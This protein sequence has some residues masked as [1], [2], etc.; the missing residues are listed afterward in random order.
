MNGNITVRIPMKTNDSFICGGEQISRRGR[1]RLNV[2]RNGEIRWYDVPEELYDATTDMGRFGTK[3][4]GGFTKFF[5]KMANVFRAGTVQLNPGFAVSNLFRDQSDA[6]FFSGKSPF[7]N[8]LKALVHFAK[9]DEVYKAYMKGGAGIGGAETGIRGSGNL[10]D[11]MMYGGGMFNYDKLKDVGRWDDR[12]WPQKGEKPELGIDYQAGPFK[13]DAEGNR[14][15]DD[16]G[17]DMEKNGKWAKEAEVAKLFEGA[18][19]TGRS[20]KDVLGLAAEYSEMVTR[21]GTFEH[22]LTGG[23]TPREAVNISRNASIDFLRMG[24]NMRKLNQIIPFLNPSVKGLYMMQNKIRKA[25][26]DVAMGVLKWGFVPTTGMLAWNSVNPN[27][28]NIPDREKENNYIIMLKGEGKAYLKIPKGHTMKF[29]LNPF[30][31]AIEKGIG[32]SEKNWGEFFQATGEGLLP[33]TPSGAITPVAKLVIEQMAN[34]NLY[35]KQPI[36]KEGTP[37][38]AQAKKNVSQNLKDLAFAV[39]GIPVLETLFGSADRTKHGME[40]LI[41]GSARNLTFLADLAF[42]KFGEGD[43]TPDKLP[44]LRRVIGESAEWKADIQGEIRTLVKEIMT[45]TRGKV[46]MARPFVKD[47]VLDPRLVP[48]LKRAVGK[49]YELLKQKLLREQELKKGLK[50][51]NWFRKQWKKWEKKL[52]G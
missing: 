42:G 44:V 24:K 35:W 20:I 34:F 39:E 1:Q 8:G 23:K 15:F 49:K 50:S 45:I 13:I 52:E 22:A 51:N 4:E 28:K 7:G 38:A 48:A 41:G 12:I 6:M 17:A 47:G 31:M 27:Y 46:Q 43:L 3:F 21:L 29:L 36:Y 2:I 37:K 30:Q 32:T 40:S 19:I 26:E 10:T 9:K 33:V 11:E 18:K 14:V 25:P 5:R 16:V